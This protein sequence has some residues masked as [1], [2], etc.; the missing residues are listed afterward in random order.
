EGA[1][2]GAGSGCAVSQKKPAW[3]KDEACSNRSIADVSAVA[4]PYTPVSVYDSY[5]VEGWLL[6]GGTSVATPFVAGVEALSSSAFRAAGPSAFTRA[7]L[8]GALNDP[9]SGENGIC[10][11]YLCVAKPGYDGPT[12]WGTPNGPLL[13]P[14][15]ITEQPTVNSTSKVTLH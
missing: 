12:G 2:S 6:F 13:L 9:T 3:Q 11:S 5:E 8:A 7:G 4:D 14:V 1:W 10:D 15:A